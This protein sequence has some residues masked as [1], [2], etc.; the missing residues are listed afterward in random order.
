MHTLLT[1]LLNFGITQGSE[2]KHKLVISFLVLSVG[3]VF[4]I[5]VRAD[6]YSRGMATNPKTQAITSTVPL[7]ASILDNYLGTHEEGSYLVL[8]G[9]VFLALGLLW[10]KKARREKMLVAAQSNSE[11][12]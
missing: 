1:W 4:T 6:F 12:D 8:E 9:G 3:A 11:G 5:A 10:L 7:V 2:V